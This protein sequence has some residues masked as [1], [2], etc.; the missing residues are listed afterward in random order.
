MNLIETDDQQVNADCDPD[1]GSHRVLAR[2]EKSFD[3]QV[4][5]DPF[6]EEFDLPSP[7][8]DGCNC[9]RRQIEVV[10][11]EGQALSRIRIE[12][13]DTPK[14]HWV[15]SFGFFSAQSNNLVATQAAG[16]IDWVGL[17]D[18]ESG[19]AFR[20]YNKVSVC[21]LYPKQSCE[22]DVSAVKDINAASLNKH[23]IHEVDVMNRTVCNLYKHRDRSGQIDLGVEFYRRF[24]FAKMSP[25]K[26]RQAQINRG[27]ING[28][29]HLTDV[30]PVGV[31]AIQPPCLA[32]QNLRERFVD[33]PISVFVCVSKVSVILRLKCTSNLRIKV[34]HFED[35]EHHQ[36]GTK[37][38]NRELKGSRVE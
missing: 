36:N 37:T 4:L 30:E 21:T 5:F 15:V 16:L 19:V 17:A 29:N 24:G 2:S 18:V 27:S 6:K 25:R 11:K 33:A 9:Q 14:L 8:V 26:H 13:A 35:V 3:A 32:N 38:S 12:K 31:L 7:F 10:R 23:L 28:I 20:P 22:V 34:Y 1:L